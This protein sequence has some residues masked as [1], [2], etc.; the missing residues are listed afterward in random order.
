MAGMRRRLKVFYDGGCHPNPGP[1]EAAAVVRGK[2][3]FFDDLGTGSNTDAEWHALRCAIE[4]A[5]DLGLRDVEFV[6]DSLEVTR[7]ANIALANG[8]ATSG[9]AISLLAIL[10]HYR[11]GR[12]RWIKREQNLA[13]IAL[14]ARRDR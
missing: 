1:M 14:E 13:G 6:G 10:A 3:Y 9:Q 4:L 7:S 12:I 11:P 5:R 2:P 8:N